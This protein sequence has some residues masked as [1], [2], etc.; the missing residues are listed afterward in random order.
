M[1]QIKKKNQEKKRIKKKI[2]RSQ[3]RGISNGIYITTQSKGR[4]ILFCNEQGKELACVELI[5]AHI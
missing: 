1:N 2:K 4:L 3:T 5:Y